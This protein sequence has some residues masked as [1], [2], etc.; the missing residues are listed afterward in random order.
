MLE[1]KTICGYRTVA[2]L[3]GKGEE[4][5]TLIR[6]ELILELISHRDIYVRLY[7]NL[8]NF[9]KLHDSLVPSLCSIAPVSKWMSFLD[10]GHLIANAYD[11]VFRF[12]EIWTM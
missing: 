10:M 1:A 8:E 9:E 2:G 6:R 11:R 7:E 5:H 4:N 12:D 3:L